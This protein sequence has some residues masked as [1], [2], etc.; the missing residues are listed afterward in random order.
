[1]DAAPDTV[2]V[3]AKAAKAG[4]KVA[5]QHMNPLLA[6]LVAS[7]QGKRSKKE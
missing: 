3:V 1:M 4:A 7:K 2:P 6:K 5:K